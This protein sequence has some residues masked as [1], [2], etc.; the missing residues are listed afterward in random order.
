MTDGYAKA[1]AN[2]D[3]RQRSRSWYGGIW[4]TGSKKNSINP[5]AS[6]CT[7][8]RSAQCKALYPA[9]SSRAPGTKPAAISPDGAELQSLN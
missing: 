9:V 8:R 2:A 4:K 3:G 1:L 6:A 5:G 7:T